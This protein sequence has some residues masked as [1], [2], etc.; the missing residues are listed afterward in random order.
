MPNASSSKIK[1]CLPLSCSGAK[2]TKKKSDG[3]FDLSLRN[4]L[5]FVFSWCVDVELI[6][7]DWLNFGVSLQKKIPR[8]RENPGYKGRSGMLIQEQQLETEP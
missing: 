5:S 1:L 4:F 7:M 3:Y 6:E 8:E 2:K